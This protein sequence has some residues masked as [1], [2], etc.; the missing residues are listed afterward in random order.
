M[1]QWT[2]DPSPSWLLHPERS[3]VDKSLIASHRVDF[4]G[5][6][7]YEKHSQA[8]DPYHEL[9]ARRSAVDV[10]DY[11]VV[12]AGSA[13]CVVA[14]RLS[15]DPDVTVCLLEAGPEDDHEGIH[16]PAAFG[17]LFRSQLDWDFD[18]HDEPFCD[19]RRI[20]LPRGRVL[21]GTSSLNAMVY[22]RGNPVDYDDWGV[23]GW[24]YDSLLPYFKKS[25]DNERGASDEHGA[26]GPLAV[27][28]GRSDNPMATAFVEAALQAGH[29]ANDDFNAGSQVGF[30]RYQ[31]TQR[32]G[33]RC[34]AARAF[35]HPVRHRPNLT[36]LTDFQVHRVKV[37][38]ARAAGVVGRRRGEER[39]IRAL[40]EV[41]VS[42]GAYGSPQ[43]LML[44]GIG[45]ADQLAPLGIPV[46]LDQP[47]VGQNLQDHP[48]VNL[49][50]A[51]SSPVSLLMAGSGESVRQYV[52]E[53]RGPLTSNGPEAGGF[54]R[55][56]D[57]S[58][59]PDV[60]FH[61]APMMFVDGG[62]AAPTH[63]AISYGPCVLKPASRGEIT[64][65]SA[66][67]TAKPRIAHRYYSA[68]EDM[69]IAVAGMRVALDIA[70]QQ[71]LRP[72]TET[73]VMAPWSDSEADLRAY[74]RR[75]TQTLYHPSGSCAMGTV[76]DAQ[77]RV[78]GV[79]GLRVI[80]AS[81]MPTVIRG[82]TN[83]PTIALAEKA[84]DLMT[85]RSLPRSQVRAWESTDDRQELEPASG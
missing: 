79:A 30:G 35:V 83:A 10:F 72:F 53:A 24:D 6:A 49:V 47:A 7:S 19:G 70:R 71:A 84:A 69:T 37:A 41:V 39:E 67:P 27:S 32:D 66:D 17:T 28:E 50:F 8:T 74:V 11:I 51:H 68:E 14:S 61:A 52:E 77:L 85:G 81:V 78:V 20:Y 76:V 73:A 48:A 63:H 21:G 22:I 82:N 60:Q 34:S 46:V 64:L 59:A 4:P 45:P 62:L 44:S 75:A 3:G 58:R 16:T 23:P 25:E 42:A 80:D 29:E 12:G 36:V 13:G 18:T 1:R 65:A 5:H 43:L 40:R 38:E 56:S 9:D 31:V 33:R 55:V 26:G 57:D 54:V 15:E 2:V